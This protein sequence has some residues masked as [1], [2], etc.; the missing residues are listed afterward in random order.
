LEFKIAL[1]EIV[2]DRTSYLLYPL[3]KTKPN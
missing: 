1:Y 2:K 3:Q